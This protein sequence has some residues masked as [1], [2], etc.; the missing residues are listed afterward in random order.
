VSGDGDV[1]TTPGR[2]F[3]RLRTPSGDALRLGASLLG[4]GAGGVARLLGSG[5][6]ADAVWALTTLV[7]LVPAGL[8]VARGLLQRRPGVDVIALMALGGSLAFGEFLAGAVIALMLS[9][10][11]YLETR[12]AARA[13]SELRALL[14]HAPSVVHRLENGT[15]TSPPL[16]AVRAGDLLLVASGEVVPVDGRVVGNTA[17]LD[18]SALTGEAE[19]VEVSEGDP[20]RSGGV[21]AGGPFRLQATAGAD[22]STYAGIVRLV[23]DAASSR[24][25][26]TRVADRFALWFVPLTLLLALGAALIAHDPVRALAVIVVATPCPLILAAPVA[27]VCGMSRAARRGVVVKSGAALEALGRAN[28]LLFDKTGT[29]TAGQARLADLETSGGIAPDEIV[30]LAASL[31]QVSTHPLALPILHAA[32]ERGLSLEMPQDASEQPGRGIRGRIGGHEVAV[33]RAAFVVSGGPVPE[34]ARRVRRRTA[35]EGMANVFVGIDGTLCGALV[36]EDPIRP[37]S[38]YTMQ[39]LRQAGIRRLIMVTGDHPEVAETVG[40]AL[41]VDAVRAERSP[42]DK[43]VVV[44]EEQDHATV[45]MVGDGINDAPALAAA[46]VG[47]AMGAR[48]A[49]ASSEAADVVLLVDRL[50]RLAEGVEIARRSHRIAVQSIA[51]GMGLSLVAMIVAA[52]GGLVPVLG[53]VV[54]EIIDLAVI[55]NALR[56]LG[57]GRAVRR[58]TPAAVAAARRVMNEHTTLRRGTARIREVADE[59]G[60]VAPTEA[61]VHLDE[62]Q[63]FLVEELLPHER[64][65]ER[66]FYP[67]VAPY[68]GGEDAV[69]SARRTHAEIAHLVR[70]LGRMIEDLPPGGP[71]NEDLA[72]L[73]RILYGLNAVLGL[74]R[75]EEDAAR[76]SR[77]VDEPGSLATVEGRRRPGTVAS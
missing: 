6:T 67:L 13:R 53:A 5:R 42:A 72:G 23:R 11:A 31:D 21:N 30:R 37:D 12:A 43:V 25:P 7:A 69:E 4:L 45:V 44:H 24:A 8:T 17:V 36:I 1:S 71:T 46:D 26:L 65:E 66:L 14:D 40:A 3:H 33:G 18:E 61:R 20:V 10:G 39:R 76:L 60:R 34:W 41:G 22:D 2:R 54:Q 59:L 68:V 50:D 57:S 58:P 27:L 48:G 32:R 55:L 51:A 9:T 64:D 63:R 56:A 15:L 70:V 29:L 16:T 19:P 77:L 28:V 35:F 74:H 47:V 49:T 75:A 62:V 52:A 38:A 73:R